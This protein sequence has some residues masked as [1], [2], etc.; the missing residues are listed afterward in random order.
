M[1]DIEFPQGMMW[2][3]P[4]QGAPDYVRGSVSIKREELI[5]WL[6]N[7]EG[8]WV[9]LDL[10]ESKGG[11]V[12][13]SVNDWKPEQRGGSSGS[14]GGAPHRQRQQSTKPA[15]VDDLDSEDIPFATNRSV[16]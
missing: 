14:R 11:K 4:R 7:R 5:E 9:N 6:S 15:P 10:K 12:Y 8:E 1:S 2:K 13:F 16:W 3:E